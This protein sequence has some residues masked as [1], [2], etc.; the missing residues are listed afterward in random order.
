MLDGLKMDW[1][2]A[3]GLLD[4]TLNYQRGL[5][6]EEL[7]KLGKLTAKALADDGPLKEEERKALRLR[8]T[9]ARA[10]LKKMPKDQLS[11][12]VSIQA[13]TEALDGVPQAVGR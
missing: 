11:P 1:L 13:L 6:E 10:E 12:R 8:V 3:A 4:A 7:V 9:M 5:S 2:M